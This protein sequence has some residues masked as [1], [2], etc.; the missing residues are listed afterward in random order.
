MPRTKTTL[1]RGDRIAVR[2]GAYSPTLRKQRRD[3]VEREIRELLTGHLSHLV[4]SDA[5]LIDQAVDVATQLRLIREYFDSQ[6]GSLVTARGGVRSSATLYIQLHR[7]LIQLWDR[8][9]VGPR[10]QAELMSALGM[11]AVRELRAAD[12]QRRLRERH[13]GAGP[14]DLHAPRA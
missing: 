5:P 14:G 12:A 4:P 8:L 10:S 7:L 9:G 11:P 13:D 1:K 2:H 6:G 3:Q